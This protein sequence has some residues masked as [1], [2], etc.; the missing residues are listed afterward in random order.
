MFICATF[1]A[2][3]GWWNEQLKSD[4][5]FVTALKHIVNPGFSE[6]LAERK[7]RIN[8]VAPGAVNTPMLW[9]NAN[10][11]S[12]AE[13]VEGAVG[14]PHD[15]AAAICFLAPGEARFITGTTFVVDGGRLD[16]L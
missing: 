11:K 5:T 16:I 6:E 10:V 4:S 8:C 12:G 13:K 2:P 7:I 3:Y 14:Q 1:S 9:N 15:I